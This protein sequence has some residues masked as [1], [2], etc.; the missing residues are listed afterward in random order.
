MNDYSNYSILI[1]D[2]V[3]LNVLLVKKMLARM[4]MQMYTASNGQ[5]ALNK[6]AENKPDL[7]LLDL[8][9]P[10]MDGFEVLEHLREDESTK[11]IKV[12]VLSALNNETEIV[13]AMKGGAVDFIAKPIIMER[14]I[15]CITKQLDAIAK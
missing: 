14:L 13:R 12:V 8:M 7:I 11:D 1:V 2:D 10:V 5:D 3:P 9:M 6:L 15:N 4:G